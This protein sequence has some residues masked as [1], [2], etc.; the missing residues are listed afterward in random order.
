MAAR[1]SATLLRTV[2]HLDQFTTP[3]LAACHERAIVG[4]GARSACR[5]R[6][7]PRSPPGWGLG[8]D[9][10]PQRRGRGRF[11]ARRPRPAAGE[12]WRA[13]FGRY[14][15][16]VGGIEPRKGTLDLVEAMALLRAQPRPCGS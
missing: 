4:A 8:A 10:D 15:L 2:H 7:R 6:S 1:G 14:V 16:A 12:P 5:R 3:E 11:A 9:G 13:R